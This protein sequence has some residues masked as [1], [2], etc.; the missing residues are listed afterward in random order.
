MHRLLLLI[1]FVFSFIPTS[2][3]N[4]NTNAEFRATWIVTWE[5]INGNNSVDG[6]KNLTRTIL[7]NH[8]KANMNAVVWQARQGGTVYFESSYEPWGSYAGGRRPGYDAL[9]Y[10]I[11]EAHRRDM[12][13][14]AWFNVFHTSSTS[15]GTPAGDHPEWICRER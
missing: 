14:H 8:K 1:V 13:F 12:E 3:A 6:N 15:P 7:D 11:E 10:A 4:Q 9:A 5:W 2:Y